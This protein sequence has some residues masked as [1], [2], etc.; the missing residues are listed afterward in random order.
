MD[1]TPEME[2]LGSEYGIVGGDANGVK[3]EILE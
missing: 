2:V 1:G 3:C